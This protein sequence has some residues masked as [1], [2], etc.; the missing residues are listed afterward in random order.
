MSAGVDDCQ[1]Q[2]EAERHRY[3]PI[4]LELGIAKLRLAKA[5]RGIV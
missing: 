2:L 3:V 1:R 4:G 5:P